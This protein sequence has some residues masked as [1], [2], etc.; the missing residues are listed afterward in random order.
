[1]G[2][3]PMPGSALGPDPAH[4]RAV[5]MPALGSPARRDAALRAPRPRA[6]HP[7]PQLE[8]G[9]RELASWPG[10]S[11]PIRIMS[12]SESPV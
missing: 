6:D 3:L 4:A 1:M 5:V 2:Q 11:N 7:S 12:K 10:L 9:G 8:G